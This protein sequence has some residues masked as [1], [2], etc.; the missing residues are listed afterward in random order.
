TDPAQALALAA[1]FAWRQ[2][3]PPQVTKYFEAQLD[4]RGD[5]LV[6]AATDFDRGRTMTYRHVQLGGTN[7]QA[8]VYGRRRAQISRT[9]IPLHGISLDGKMAV[10]TEPLRRL[11]QAEAAARDKSVAKPD[12]ICSVSG[13]AVTARGQ[14]VYAETGSGVLCFCGTDHYDLVNQQ[15][16][17]AESGGTGGVGGSGVAGVGAPMNDAWTHGIKTLLYMRVNFPDDLTEPISEAAAYSVMNSVNTF[18]T[19]GSYDQTALDS[20]VTPLVTLPQTK[21]YYSADPGLLL[22]DARAAVKQAGFDTANYN[23]DIVAF[24]S[25]PNYTFGGLAYVGGKGVWLQSMGTGVTAHELGHNYGL[26]HANFWDTTTNASMIG[27]GTNLEYGNVYDTMGL[28]GG[29]NYQFNA[30]HKNKLDWLTADAVQVVSTN[31]VYRIYPFDVP[32]SALVN[33]RFYAAAVQKDFQRYYWLE[34]RRLFTSNPW[35]Q[36]GVLLNWS[37][38]DESNG[39]TQLI[40][41]TP[42]SP[43]FSGDSRDDAALV[44]G[45]TFDDNVAGVHITPLARGATGPEPWLDVLVNTGAFPGNQPPVLAVEVDNTNVAP[46]ALVHFHATATDPD[47]DTLAYSW[48]FD[49]LSF[50][51]NNLPWTSKT[52]P[53]ANDHVVRCVV[54]D[55][56][57]GMASANVVVTVGAADGFRITGRVTDTN[58]LPLQGVLVSNGSNN[59]ADFFGGWTGRDRRFVIANVGGNLTLNAVQFGHTFAGTANWP[60]PLDVTNNLG[61]VDFTATPLPTVNIV[62]DTNTVPESDGLAHYFTLTRTGDTNSDFTVPLYISGTA[63]LGSDYTLSPTIV[64][65]LV[66]IPA[67]TNSLTF[68]FHAQNNGVVK[69][70]E[71][72]TLTLLDDFANYTSP[73]YALAPPAAATITILDDD[74]PVQPTVTLTTPTPVISDFGFD[75]GEFVF[76]R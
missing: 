40:D 25:V 19:T 30:A 38:W 36:N 34:F 8:F 74:S 58:G 4:G 51:T 70:P 17:L 44:V 50:S 39:G 41:T 3:L 9:G 27:P 20:T 68:T 60:N 29:G 76:T 65:N 61:G 62:A 46:G 33:G 43:T 56:K 54:S 49:D 2:Q 35:T 53:M 21:A 10:S 11:S 59:L 7:Y 15:W 64:S 42:G 37:P 1:P 16:A 6:A 13:Q 24:T 75:A 66:T 22:A 23:L 14:P 52:F 28:A 55:M 26:W 47:G 71:T 18:Y 32:A 12:V 57:G 31:G 48:T 63:T 72:A 45:R 5:F 67:G 69:G 73:G